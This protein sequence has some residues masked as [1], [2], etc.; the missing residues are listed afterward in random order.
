MTSAG[1]DEMLFLLGD[2]LLSGRLTAWERNF[3]ASVLA[4]AR[5]GGPEW[6]PTTKQAAVLDRLLRRDPEGALEPL[7][8][9]VGGDD[10]L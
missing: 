9:D 7:I 4:A 2:R 1:L 3:A 10:G 5:R 6:H 8:E